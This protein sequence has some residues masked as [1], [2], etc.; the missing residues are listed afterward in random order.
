MSGS[1]SSDQK[2]IELKSCPFCGVC[3]IR[4]NAESTVAIS[5]HRPDCFFAPPTFEKPFMVT[6]S[7]FSR[8]NN[9]HE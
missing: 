9:R 1:D 6:I 8:W 2:S 5:Q 3:P 7:Q 4:G